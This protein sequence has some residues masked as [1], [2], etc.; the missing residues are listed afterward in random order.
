MRRFIENNGD[1]AL[2]YFFERRLAAFFVRKKPEEKEFIGG[3]PRN[4][5][6]GSECR[7]PR[8]CFNDCF[9]KPLADMSDEPRTG[10]RD[11]GR[12]RI[13]DKCYVFPRF[14]PREYFVRLFYFRRRVEAK[15][16]FFEPVE[17]GRASCRERV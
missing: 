4:R 2:R 7:R 8:Y 16:R 10:V 14:E 5:K 13:G 3:E 1:R 9:R 12:T 17:I 6:R 11:A 15:N